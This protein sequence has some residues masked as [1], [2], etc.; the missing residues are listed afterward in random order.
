[1]K[2]FAP[3]SALSIA[4]DLEAGTLSPQDVFEHQNERIKALEETLQV[5][6]SSV[7]KA[8]AH[9]GPLRGISIGVKDI[10]DTFDMPTGHNSPIYTDHHP[11]ADSSLV[12]MLREAGATIAG[13][14]VTTEFAFFHPGPT[15]NPHNTNHTPGGSSSGSAAGVAAG[16][17]PAAI[18]SQ[19]GGSVVRPAAFCGVSGYKPSFRLFPTVGMK[20]F[21]WLLD[22]AGFFAASAADNAFVASACS[23]RNLQ[24]R[25]ADIS[26][27]RIGVFR[28]KADHLQSDAMQSA[29]E[30]MI[31]AAQ[32]AGASV[33]EITASEEFEACDA[34]HSTIQDY[35]A[36]RALGFERQNHANL[37]SPMLSDHLAKAALVTSDAYDNA[38]RTAN[39]A[40]KA[41]HALFE[42]CDIL[43]A[44]SAPGAAPEGLASTGNSVF[45]RPWTLLGMPCVNVPGTFDANAMPLG[46]Q[47]IAPFGQDQK[48]LQAAHW[49]EKRV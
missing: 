9:N 19:T 49:L 11:R 33:V 14:T 18:G 42:S 2:P 5:F 4:R 8:A 1:M 39:R 36:Y 34:A 44:P 29:I 24:V 30:Q 21:S 37:L 3:L 15:R 16:F 27:P 31:N 13:K 41:S 48:A 17:F 35:E 40:R 32:A 6:A 38:R 45:N 22:T 28:Q 7:P 20:C 43:I 12:A 46:V 26:A 10:Y 23:G 25:E 47:V